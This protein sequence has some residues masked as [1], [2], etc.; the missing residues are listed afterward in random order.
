MTRKQLR[1]IMITFLTLIIMGVTTYAS[2]NM[3]SSRKFET[4]KNINYDQL[5]VEKINEEEYIYQINIP[6]GNDEIYIKSERTMD[7]VKNEDGEYQIEIPL[8]EGDY[9]VQVQYDDIPVVKHTEGTNYG[10][11]DEYIW[12]LEYYEILYYEGIKLF[13][14]DYSSISDVIP[15]GLNS[16]FDI[17][18]EDG[19]VGNVL[20]AKYVIEIPI[21][22]ELESGLK[23]KVYN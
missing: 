13:Y 11:D 14:Y 3:S 1:V 5:K 8:Y 20:S 17:Q 16:K 22:I 12:E 2:Y 15:I 18:Y 21:N 10:P 9:F 19:N 7:I 23:I 4:E 6:Y